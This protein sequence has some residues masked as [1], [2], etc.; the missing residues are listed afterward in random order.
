MYK[1]LMSIQMTSLHYMFI[2][3]FM[4]MVEPKGFGMLDCSFRVCVSVEM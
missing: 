2:K 4:M 1:D 3:D